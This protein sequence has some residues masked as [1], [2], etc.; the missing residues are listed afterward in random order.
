[1]WDYLALLNN[2][3]IIWGVTMVLMNMGSRYVFADL[4]K[5]HDSILA[6]EFVKKLVVFS[7]FFVAT[8]D[9][10]IA[11]ML[12]VSY[13]F[14]VDGILH[15]KRR[16]CIVPKKYINKAENKISKEE[17]LRAKA[18]V[19]KYETPVVVETKQNINLFNIYKENLSQLS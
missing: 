18:I 4:G 1:M 3:K 9:I 16:F 8:R 6:T 13:I 15:E 11:F 7:I 17:Y 14:I 5:I 10:L 19:L 12:T 2:N